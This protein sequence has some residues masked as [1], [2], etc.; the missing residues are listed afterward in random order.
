M[1][2]A[3]IQT[4]PATLPGRC[5][6]CLSGHPAREYFF[7][8][9]IDTEWEGVLYICNLCMTEIIEVSPDFATKKKLDSILDTAKGIMAMANKKAEKYEK[10]SAMLKAM[11]INEERLL[12]YGRV[13]ERS[14]SDA[15]SSFAALDGDKSEDAGDVSEESEISVGFFD[16]K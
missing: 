5:F 8:T 12:E 7:D 15:A 1:R 4:I 6:K 10:L 13:N 9:G 16:F 11:G 3:N 14:D 2:P